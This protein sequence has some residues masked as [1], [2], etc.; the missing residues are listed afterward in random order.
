M[1]LSDFMTRDRREKNEAQIGDITGTDKNK[2]AAVTS[3]EQRKLPLVGAYG[4]AYVP[5]IGEKCV[6]LPLESGDACLGVIGKSANLSPGELMLYSKGGASIIL[7]NNGQVLI[8][9]EVYGGDT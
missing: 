1:W 7:K 9:G 5:P 8:N 3:L 4:I 2:V 6:V